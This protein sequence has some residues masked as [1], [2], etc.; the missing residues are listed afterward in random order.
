LC[1]EACLGKKL[2]RPYL[3]KLVAGGVAQGEDTEVK[4]HYHKK[5]DSID[6]DFEFFV[7]SYSSHPLNFVPKLVLILASKTTS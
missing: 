6:L 2:G 4:P 5:K 3:E 7:P 1:F